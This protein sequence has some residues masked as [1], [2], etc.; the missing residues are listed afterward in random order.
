M[1]GAAVGG[2]IVSGSED[3]CRVKRLKSRVVFIGF[4]IRSIAPWMLLLVCL[5]LIWFH[6]IHCYGGCRRR[7]LVVWTNELRVTLAAVTAAPPPPQ[8]RHRS[9]C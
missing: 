3:V 4:S 6:L 1:R 2:H 8:L 9:H 5:V 7:C